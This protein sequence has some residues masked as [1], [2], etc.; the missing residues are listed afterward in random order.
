MFSSRRKQLKFVKKELINKFD[1]INSV[2]ISGNWGT[3][4]SSFVN[5]LK[6]ELLK[7]NNVD[8]INIQCG[9]EC[10]LKQILNS[11]SLQIENIM[12][13]NNIYTR[14]N[15][16]IHKYFK[17]IYN[18]V[19]NTD[20]E[21]FAHIGNLF[22]NNT[23]NFF[24]LRD[25]MNNKLRKLKDMKIYIFIDDLDRILDEESRINILKII[26]ESIN[27]DRCL[28]IFSLDMDQFLC[29]REYGY[30]EK[31]VDFNINLT[32]ISF[33][34][35]VDMYTN[36]FFVNT[37]SFHMVKDNNE[38]PKIIK[39][40]Y[41][42]II[43][44][45]QELLKKDSYK[46]LEDDINES[47]F[48]I[49]IFGSNPRKVKSLMKTVENML[50]IINE[51]WFKDAECVKNEYTDLKWIESI[52]RVSFLNIFCKECFDNLYFSDDISEYKT[53]LKN[54]Y[55]YES[56]LKKID[57]RDRQKELYKMIIH[58][59]YTMDIYNDKT[60]HQIVTEEL[61]NNDLK[62]EH[63]NSYFN[64]CISIH[65]N[66]EYTEK[67]ISFIKNNEN[68]NLYILQF[69]NHY[70]K[71]IYNLHHLKNNDY[72]K[73]T[74]Y[75]VNQTKEIIKHTQ[76]TDMVIEYIKR[77]ISG[78]TRMHIKGLN[79]LFHYIESKG[80]I[81]TSDFYII[82]TIDSIDELLKNKD[83]S[84]ISNSTIND[85][86]LSYK[87]DIKNID[88]KDLP[89]KNI[90]LDTIDL[91]ENIIKIVMNW[92]SLLDDLEKYR[93][94]YEVPNVN[95]YNMIIKYFN[96][97]ENTLSSNQD[98]ISIKLI[99]DFEKFILDLPNKNFKLEQRK[100][101]KNHVYNICDLIFMKKKIINYFDQDDWDDILLKIYNKFINF[102]D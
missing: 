4:K 52:I 28:T 36:D 83:F 35:I 8:I 25:E 81:R 14:N 37:L 79:E 87:N 66:L 47:I 67:V 88:R 55:I 39:S 62:I 29:E 73:M 75:L 86:I 70:E 15:G 94:Y 101:I 100:E 40:V 5:A 96:K 24:E 97:L 13:K 56:I 59:M 85:Y 46:N 102:A 44:S 49:K 77:I 27:L 19:E 64:Y 1:N 53:D 6:N 30:I 65:C 93:V 9:I 80:A 17:S 34:E 71:Q 41:D 76:K 99:E 16:I 10:D 58:Q 60:L 3:G 21:I 78:Y 95:E 69:I 26:Y 68:A 11:I 22:K 82:P 48:Q 89:V 61:N 74:S 50:E 43:K 98:D 20:Y 91:I 18:L 33:Y 7:D 51:V 63:L 84:R 42:D 90:F 2:V 45:F 12:K 38:I 31:Y 23:Q 92:E 57:S 54:K 32:N 72:L